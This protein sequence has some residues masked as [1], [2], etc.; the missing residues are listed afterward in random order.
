MSLS[1]GALVRALPLP[2][3]PLLPLHQNLHLGSPQDPS[4]RATKKAGEKVRAEKH[5]VLLV[6]EIFFFSPY[7]QHLHNMQGLFKNKAEVKQD[8]KLGKNSIMATVNIR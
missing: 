7:H 8:N 6:K 1:L 3:P 4:V 2:P 5:K